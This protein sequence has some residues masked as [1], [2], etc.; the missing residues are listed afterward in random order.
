MDKEP[1]GA[2]MKGGGLVILPLM[3]VGCSLPVEF[4]LVEDEEGCDSLHFPFSQQLPSHGIL[5]ANL[6]YPPPP[7]LTFGIV[8]EVGGGRS[9]TS[10]LVCSIQAIVHLCDFTI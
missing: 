2:A 6:P 3:P 1:C 5:S 8:G 10:F 9:A 7:A 4:V